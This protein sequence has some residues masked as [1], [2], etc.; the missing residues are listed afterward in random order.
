MDFFDDGQA[1]AELRGDLTALDA[2]TV[3]AR[4]LEDQ[5]REWRLIA[6]KFGRWEHL[7][8]KEVKN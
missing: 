6:E 8:V 4:R 7:I 2:D 3:T 1:M 5:G